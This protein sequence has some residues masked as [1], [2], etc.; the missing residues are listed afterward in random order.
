M[1]KF[2]TLIAATVLAVTT[3]SAAK[4]DLGAP[5]NNVKDNDGTVYYDA[6]TKTVYMHTKYDYRPG[7]WL[8]NWD[9]STGSNVAADYSNW[10]QV[11]VKIAKGDKRVGIK[12][13][14][15]GGTDE[16]NQTYFDDDEDGTIT[17]P[18]NA[19]LKK[20][21]KQMYFQSS[22]DE[23]TATFVEAYA[24]N[25][26]A[27]VTSADLWTGDATT[28][29]WGTPPAL[30]FNF[31]DAATPL[32]KAG[33]YIN[34]YFTA[35]AYEEATEQYYQ[36]CIM[37]SWWTQLTGTLAIPNTETSGNNNITTYANT[38]TGCSFQLTDDDVA[39]LTKQK[40]MAI[41]GHGL[42]VTKVT[43]SKE[44]EVTSVKAI[45]AAKAAEDAPAYNLSGQRVSKSYRG[46]VIKGGK[47]YI[48][49]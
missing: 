37:G 32:L 7:W 10:D 38:T 35:H 23:V 22:E 31:P 30:N 5:A 29:G 11:V 19:D 43:V 14:Y 24:E 33:N 9:N 39:T 3:A 15:D 25:G 1:K 45:E 36:S 8:M 2:F 16:T 28:I 40:G 26:K 13:E 47:K 20:G 21:V 44:A 17:I 27:E 6:S 4:L 41:A 12:F 46:I 34:I 49:K 42:D 18:L 48:V